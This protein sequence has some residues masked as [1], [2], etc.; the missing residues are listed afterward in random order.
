MLITALICS[1]EKHSMQFHE[2]HH[3][4]LGQCHAIT[5]LHVCQPRGNRIGEDDVSTRNMRH[6][7]SLPHHP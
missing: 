4:G 1:A 3:H 2:A 7:T 5:F 6:V